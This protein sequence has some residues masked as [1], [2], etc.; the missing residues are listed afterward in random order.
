KLSALGIT[1][2]CGEGNYCADANVTREQMAAFLLRSLGEFAPPL[3]TTQRFLDVAPQSP[4]YRF[5]EQ[6]ALRQ[7]TA[8]CGGGNYCPGENVT[9][10]QMAAFL[11]RAF[12]L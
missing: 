4:F 5:I 10:G 11:V 12:G 7:I 1:S 3:P 2:G 9:R 8:G 6:M